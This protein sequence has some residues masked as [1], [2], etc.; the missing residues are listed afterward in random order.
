M[1][2]GLR[3]VAV[4]SMLGAAGVWAQPAGKEVRPKLGAYEVWNGPLE[5]APK[6][7][8]LHWQQ[9]NE[10]LRDSVGAQEHW[11][12]DKSKEAHV[13]WARKA[14]P[15]WLSRWEGRRT[16]LER[17]SS[18]LDQRD[19]R[20]ALFASALKAHVL[21]TELLVIADLLAPAVVTGDESLVARISQAYRDAEVARREALRQCLTITAGPFT[22]LEPWLAWCGRQLDS[23]A[24]VASELSVAGLCAENQGR[25]RS[26][27]WQVKALSEA[28]S[29]VS[30]PASP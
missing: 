25:S 19:P 28:C 27:G 5:Q 12:F 20:Q 15:E 22:H 2:S 1:T 9:L 13:E 7:V 11:I 18:G 3:L 23:S 21:T 6:P 4:A 26:R 17:T 29:V 8:Q 16:Q 10:A 24:K 30:R 14:I